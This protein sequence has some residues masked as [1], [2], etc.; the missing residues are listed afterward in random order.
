[1][2]QG[3]LNN[4]VLEPPIKTYRDGKGEAATT[5]EQAETFVE[6]LTEAERKTYVADLVT[7]EWGVRIVFARRGPVRGEGRSLQTR[8]P[9][10]FE[11]A[12]GGFGQIRSQNL[13]EGH[14][15]NDEVGQRPLDLDFASGRA[16]NFLRFVQKTQGLSKD[17]LVAASL[18][19]ARPR[20]KDSPANARL[21]VVLLNSD[22]E[23]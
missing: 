5:T 13:I 11:K 12:G 3:Q 21:E 17:R 14:V 7:D 1:M 15:A 20:I 18:G 10:V 16:V 8:R 4:S 23:L 9:A 19:D 2:N 22:M 6:E